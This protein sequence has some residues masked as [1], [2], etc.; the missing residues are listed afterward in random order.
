MCHARLLL[1][2]LDGIFKM[3]G[4]IVYHMRYSRGG[5]TGGARGAPAPPISGTERTKIRL[6]SCLFS[7]PISVM[8]PLILA[9]CAALEYIVA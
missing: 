5:R 4:L 7:W 6:D 3:M 9:P 8:H 2:G 1:F